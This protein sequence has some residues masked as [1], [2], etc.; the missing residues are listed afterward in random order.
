M[1]V[2]VAGAIGKQLVPLL[3]AEGHEVFGTTRSAVR[4]EAVRALGATALVV[5]ALDPDQVAAAVAEAEPE[6]IVHEL[7]ALS[8]AL[9]M[10]HFDRSLEPTNRLR[11]GQDRGGSARPVPSRVD[12]PRHVPRWLGRLLAGEAAVAMMTEV[13]GPRTRRQSGS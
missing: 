7:T 10:R 9:D 5:D 12:A 3:A 2:L 13:R 8:G 4:R 6:A 11:T 1:K